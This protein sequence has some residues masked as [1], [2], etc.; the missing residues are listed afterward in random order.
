A[1]ARLDRSPKANRI[2]VLPPRRRDHQDHDHH[3]I[4]DRGESLPALILITCFCFESGC[5]L[6]FPSSLV[7]LEQLNEL[8][9]PGRL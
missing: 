1:D 7:L 9:I 6:C 5:T 3:P 2:H 8:L 4:Q